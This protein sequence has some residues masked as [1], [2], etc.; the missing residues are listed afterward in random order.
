MLFSNELEKAKLR[1]IVAAF[2]VMLLVWG[3]SYAPSMIPQKEKE[4]LVIAGRRLG[5][6]PENSHEYVQ[7][8]SEE[9]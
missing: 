4:N 5:L 6:E 1:T 3:A 8:T 2:A 9:K 7:T